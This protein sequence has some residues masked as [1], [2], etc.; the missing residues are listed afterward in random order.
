MGIHDRDYYREDYAKKNGLKYD[1]KKARY[2]ADLVDQLANIKPSTDDE[3]QPF[4]DGKTVRPWHPVL[5]AVFWAV[6]F[7]VLFGIFKAL[8][9]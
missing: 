2:R 7:L 9:H 8:R 4:G 6:V 1:P 3:E 5:I